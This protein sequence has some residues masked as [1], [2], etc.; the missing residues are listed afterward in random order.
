MTLRYLEQESPERLFT[1]TAGR[2]GTAER[3]L[4]TATLIVS[5]CDPAP[6]TPSEHA[7]ILRLCRVPTPVGE[8]AAELGLP[9]SVVTALLGDLLAAGRVAARRPAPAGRFRPPPRETLEQ[10]LYALQRL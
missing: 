6:G 10:V 7:R 5:V 4:D 3:D 8:V 1:L 9:V 2:V